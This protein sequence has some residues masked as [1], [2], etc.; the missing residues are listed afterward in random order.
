VFVCIFLLLLLLLTY[1]IHSF[2]SR[3]CS[4]FCSFLSSFQKKQSS[5]STSS[6]SIATIGSSSNTGGGGV[7]K[8]PGVVLLGMHRSGTS[9]LGGLLSEAMGFRVGA[10][11]ELIHGADPR[12]NVKGFFERTDMVLQNDELMARQRVDYGNNIM[13]YDSREGL[14]QILAKE[15]PFVLGK[16]GLAFLNQGTINV[17][18]QDGVGEKDVDVTWMQK[19][20]RMC[21][22]LRTW[23]PL[24]DA[25][26]AIIFTYRHPL[27]VAKSLA[28]RGNAFP[29]NR[30]LNL[31]LKYN[32]LGIQNSQDLCRV[33][34]SNNAILANPKEE[35]Q[36][37]CTE[38]STNCGI[39]VPHEMKE[40][41]VVDFVDPSLHRNKV[42]TVAGFVN[43]ECIVPVWTSEAKE[44]RA[45][46]REEKLYK[47]AMQVYCDLGSGAAMRAS[48]K[49]PS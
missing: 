21:I 47:T 35:L 8:S 5:S 4:F 7:E 11:K 1:F 12:D 6:S 33:V 38:L 31:W 2:S 40:E 43:G 41:F 15:I 44:E 23:L 17:R 24:L 37:I 3:F 42:K 28:A 18:G 34:S 10:F 48:Y 26:P 16:K 13:A 27:E 32:Q 29:V 39:V 9:M 45:R 30:G 49:W 46:G 14:R 20:P 36:R 19:D 22:T 25:L